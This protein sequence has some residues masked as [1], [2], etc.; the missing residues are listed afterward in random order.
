MGKKVEWFAIDPKAD[1]TPAEAL[2]IAIRFATA[3]QHS[4]DEIEE[5][6]ISE[7]AVIC[8]EAIDTLPGECQRHFTYVG[9]A[10]PDNPDDWEER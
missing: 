1:L 10:D 6:G 3:S 9:D 4:P 5:K 7:K 2:E 8:A